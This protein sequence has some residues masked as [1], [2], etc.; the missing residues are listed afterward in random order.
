MVITCGDGRQFRPE[1]MDAKKST[2]FNLT[3]FEFVNIEGSLIDRREPKAR[4]FNFRIFFQGE[5]NI[6]RSNSFEVSSRDRRPWRISHPMYDTIVVHPVSL[7]YDDTKQ[8]T[9]EI[10]GTLIE[11]ISRNYPFESE[12]PEEGIRLN[13]ESASDDSANFANDEITINTGI[14]DGN[15]AIYN[16]VDSLV[17]TED[18]ENYFNLLNEANSKIFEATSVAD[19]KFQ[20]VVDT[21]EYLLAPA[22]FALGVRDRISI[23]KSQLDILIGLIPNAIDKN[24]KAIFEWQAGTLVNG[25]AL[26][27]A[28]PFEADYRNGTAV[29]QIAESVTEAFDSYVTQIDSFQTDNGAETDSYSPNQQSFQSLTTL[30]NYAIGN[31]LNI[32]FNAR[33]EREVLLYHDTNIIELA[34]RFYG[35]DDADQN[36][37]DLIEQNNWGITNYLQVLKNTT[38]KYYQ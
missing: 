18:A 16:D 37:R 11:T 26:S 2:E 3:E 1:W 38:V 29:I 14:S 20:S 34:H 9:T 10:S 28:S 12:L 23:I 6:E 19:S 5:D 32:A 35:L 17:P 24:Q 8:N 25:I 15:T 13:S 30:V 21:Q 33:Q 22:F 7:S 4:R 27:T 36:I 31:L